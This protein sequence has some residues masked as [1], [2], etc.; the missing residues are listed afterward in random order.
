MSKKTVKKA[1][2]IDQKEKITD[3]IDDFIKK[4]RELKSLV[5]KLEK[6]HDIEITTTKKEIKDSI[7]DGKGILKPLKVPRSLARLLDISDSKKRPKTEITHLVCEYISKKGLRDNNDK[8]VI[9]PNKDL[10]AALQLKKKAELTFMN[11]PEII[12]TVYKN[13]EQRLKKA[14]LDSSSSSDSD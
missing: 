8:K 4:G 1:N 9:H 13:E 6:I 7:A 5:E 12:N 2:F 14:E 10:L 11:L 3:V